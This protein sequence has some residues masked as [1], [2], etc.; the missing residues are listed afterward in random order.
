TLLAGWRDLLQQWASEGR[1]TAA[2]LDALNLDAAPLSLLQ[3]TDRLALGNCEDLPAVQLLDAAAMDGA[4]GAYA[5]SNST[6]FLNAHWLATADERSVQAVLT[7]EL[8]HHLDALLNASDTPGDEG[9]LLAALLLA[10]ELTAEQRARL[11]AESDWG[12]VWVDGAV[13]AVERANIT[14]TEG[15][16]VLT[17]TVGADSIVGLGGNDQL[18]GSDGDDTLDGGAGDDYL[19]PGTGSQ[20]LVIGGIGTDLMVVDRRSDTIATTARSYASL[21]ATPFAGGI[22]LATTGT[23]NNVVLAGSG[24]DDLNFSA[25]DAS[26]VV[27]LYGNDGNDYLSGGAGNDNSNA[28]GSLLLEWWRSPT[29]AHITAGLYG[30][31]GNDTLDGGAGDDYLDGGDGSDLYLITSSTDHAAAEI[32]DSGTTGS[33]ELR[34]ASSTAAQTLTVFAADTG[35]EKVT[36]GTGTAAAPDTTASTALN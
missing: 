31:A 35:L 3:L 22:N 19:D 36:I 8:G 4:M 9:A 28:Y 33:D 10:G 12:V 25:S 32:S 29:G 5:S 30:G 34:F 20:E 26:S 2:V 23:E 17:G 16:D 21:P 24:N 13:L 14:G 6:I 1:F 7:E 18:I 11:E 27:G 15:D